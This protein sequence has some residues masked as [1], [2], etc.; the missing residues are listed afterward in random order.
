MQTSLMEVIY[1]STYEVESSAIKLITYNEATRDLTVEFK[2][3]SVYKYL[4]VPLEEVQDML[5]SP[6]KG[7]YFNT[8]IRGRYLYQKQ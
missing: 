3:G 4:D 8:Y 2:K 5:A 1:N 6:S 7:E